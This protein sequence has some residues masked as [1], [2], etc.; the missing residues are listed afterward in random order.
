MANDEFLITIFLILI[1]Y[2]TNKLFNKD[3]YL[4]EFTA[5]VL[6]IRGNEV[7]LNRTAFFPESGGQTGDT[8]TLNNIE[9]LDTKLDDE[10]ILHVLKEDP[11]F[12]EGDI[13]NGKI[14]WERRYKIMKLHTASHIMEYFLWKYF[15]KMNRAGSLVDERK[16]RADYEHNGKLD[17]SKLEIVEKETNDFLGKGYSVIINEDENGVRHWKCGPVEMLCAGTHV[18]NTREIDKIKLKRKNPGKGVERIET[19]LSE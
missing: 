18:K 11:S 4:R 8:G 13:V 19:S 16:D 15:G 10:K 5:K 2:A 1:M 12:E 3:P 7:I 14:N 17:S 6:K 9:V